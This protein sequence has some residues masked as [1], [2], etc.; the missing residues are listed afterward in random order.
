MDLRARLPLLLP[1]A[2]A[3]VQAQA[4]EAQLTGQALN[5]ST[6]KLAGEVGVAHPK[7][8]RI[9]EVEPLPMPDDPDLRD[10]AIQAGLLGPGIVGLTFDYSVFIRRGYRTVRLLRHEFRHVYQYEQ[11]GSICAFMRNYLLQIVDVGYHKAALEIDARAHE[12]P[13][14]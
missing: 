1:Q 13:D 8:I 12:Q 7:L 4:A 11:A 3:W 14:P 10:A 6:V 2:I 9:A 5:A